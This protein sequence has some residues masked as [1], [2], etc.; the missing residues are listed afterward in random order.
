[1]LAL[2]RR[3]CTS[4]DGVGKAA[5]LGEGA[6]QGDG[7][8]GVQQLLGI[9]ATCGVH[10]CLVIQGQLGILLSLLLHWTITIDRIVGGR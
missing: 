8:A 2:G 10:S 3:S 4:W 6:G 9:K 7:G 5:V 1:M